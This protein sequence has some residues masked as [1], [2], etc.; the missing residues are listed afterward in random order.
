MKGSFRQSMAWLH[1]WSGLLV[2]WV[3][4]AV[5]LTGTAAYFRP[6][7]SR[8]MQPEAGQ[9][10]PVLQSAPAAV[11]FLQ[12]KV[13]DAFHWDIFLPG[14]REAVTRVFWTPRA[15]SGG[16]GRRD[17]RLH[18][19]TLDAASGE[20]VEARATRGGEFLYRFH[21]DLYY[22]PVRW[23][24]WIVGFCAMLM[25]VAI[26]S[27]IV[28]HKKF[29]ADFFTLR[30]KKGQRSW[31]DAHAVTAV[32][33]LPFHL[34]ITYTG[35]VALMFLY[36]PWGVEARYASDRAFFQEVFSP[37][38]YAERTGVAAPLADLAPMIRKASEIWGGGM[39]GHI[40]VRHPG[41]E[42]ATIR[43]EPSGAGRLAPEGHALVF[44]G[45]TGEL[46]TEE[47]APPAVQ[48]HSAMIGLHSG[49]FASPW[50]RWLYFLSGVGGT[51][52]VAT[53][54][55]MWIV[56]R[57]QKLPDPDRPHFGFRLVEKLNIG[58]IAG[59][60]IG[61][62]AYFL[63]NRLLPVGMPGRAGWE[64]H[65]FFIAWGA[66]FAWAL[67]RPARRGWI[68]ALAAGAAAYALVPLA[69]AATTAHGLLPS[70]LA[71]DW[72]FVGFDLVM[73]ATAAGLAGAAMC[74]ARHRPKVR[75]SRRLAAAA[76]DARTLA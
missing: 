67:L 75:A 58:T 36:M 48:T 17:R 33:S 16:P 45:A 49:R 50:L 70:L 44:R 11:G 21:F 73:L 60:P 55:L 30:L 62:A 39:P 35:L 25:L 47:G 28:T 71:A 13:P 64:I 12:R 9:P 1:T 22:M 42:G 23:G 56:K 27:G 52:M 40:A 74:M 53:G 15:E 2:G 76:P 32:L 46:L 37:G 69:N 26:I 57:R 29:F 66:V 51:V 61:L 41:D 59:L 10:A 38:R 8:W 31:L 72:L 34:M 43:M 6:E 4:F 19:A 7:I 5:F 18:R 24:R 68:E 20:A 3:L 63:A 65:A 54:L 14:D